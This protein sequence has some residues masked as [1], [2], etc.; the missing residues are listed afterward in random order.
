M[1]GSSSIF[2]RADLLEFDRAR[3]G[4]L[5]IEKYREVLD[6]Y[7]SCRITREEIPIQEL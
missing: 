6:S 3:Q 2:S 1:Y 4:V 7:L 5:K